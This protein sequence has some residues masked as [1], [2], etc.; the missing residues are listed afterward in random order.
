[1]SGQS[2]FSLSA[3]VSSTKADTRH[4]ARNGDHFPEIGDHVHLGLIPPFRVSML[5]SKANSVRSILVQYGA[6]FM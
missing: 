6:V 3:L 4:F 5:E 1:M 2:S